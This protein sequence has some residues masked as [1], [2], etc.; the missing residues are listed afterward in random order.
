MHHTCFKA[1]II[2][3]SRLSHIHWKTLNL[4]N[5]LESW[6]LAWDAFMIWNQLN[7]GR[8]SSW[9]IVGPQISYC[10]IVVI[11]KPN[12]SLNKLEAAKRLVWIGDHTPASDSSYDQEHQHAEHF[13]PCYKLRNY[14]K[15]THSRW[16]NDKGLWSVLTIKMQGIKPQ[17]T[18]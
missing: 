11:W 17:R 12:V 13:H 3:Q 10:Q 9:N 2:C 16:L 15:K 8:H 1:A 5:K 7:F 18:S 4:C 14:Q 6:I